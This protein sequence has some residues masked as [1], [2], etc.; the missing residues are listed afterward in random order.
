MKAQHGKNTE[1]CERTQKNGVNIYT[2]AMAGS[3]PTDAALARCDAGVACEKACARKGGGVPYFTPVIVPPL[4]TT[5]D[6]RSAQIASSRG[7]IVSCTL[8]PIHG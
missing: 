1:E 4:L 8:P 3:D 5:N 7:S 6:S 2:C